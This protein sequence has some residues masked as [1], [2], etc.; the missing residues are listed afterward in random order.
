VIIEGV[1]RGGS[2]NS[3][4]QK[5]NKYL[6]NK[7]KKINKTMQGLP[8]TREADWGVEGVSPGGGIR[9]YWQVPAPPG[10]VLPHPIP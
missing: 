10:L 9:L 6:L 5:L 1:W 7:K 2:R 4:E 3:L 8:V